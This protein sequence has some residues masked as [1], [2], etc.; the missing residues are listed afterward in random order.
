MDRTLASASTPGKSK[1]GSDDNEGVL[2]I[3]QSSSI[4]EPSPSDYL[5]SYPGNSFGDSCPSVE[6]QSVYS[7]APN[8]LGNPVLKIWVLLHCH[9]YQVYSMR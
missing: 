9:N 4:T 3:S 7:T 6:T 2:L 8:R 5:V 1:L